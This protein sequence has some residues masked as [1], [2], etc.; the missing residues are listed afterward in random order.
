MSLPPW[1][2]SRIE[3]L[4][5]TTPLLIETPEIN[6]NLYV[7][8]PDWAGL[9]RMLISSKYRKS[10]NIRISSTQFHQPQSLYNRTKTCWWLLQQFSNPNCIREA[11]MTIH[12]Y[13]VCVA[14]GSC[15]EHLLTW[16]VVWLSL[17]V[18]LLEVISTK[19]MPTWVR[20][21]LIL[22]LPRNNNT[23][24]K[25]RFEN[26]SGELVVFCAFL[27]LIINDINYLFGRNILK[28]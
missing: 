9:L 8:W 5:Q 11:E 7:S 26:S 19:A 2:Y 14:S 6:R 15:I 4:P 18:V 16:V 27:L 10:S 28:W 21:V 3:K 25:N 23:I 13:R 1:L 24:T 17:I 22:M 12:K 20:I